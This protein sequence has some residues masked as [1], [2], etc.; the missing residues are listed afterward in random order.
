MLSILKTDS[1]QS[2]LSIRDLV[3]E[4]R[5]RESVVRAVDRV[6]FGVERGET[7]GIVGESGSGKSQTLMAALGLLASNANATGKVLFQGESLLDQSPGALNRI[8][9]DKIAMVFQDPMTALTPHLKI[10]RQLTE[11]LSAHQTVTRQQA[12]RRALDMLSAVRI[13]DPSRVFDSYPHAL[14]GGMRQRV[15][16]AIALICEPELLIADEPT[17]ALDV[18]VQAQILSLLDDI[19]RRMDLS[20]VLVSHDLGVIAQHC[21]RVVVMYAGRIVEVANAETLFNRPLHPYTRALLD[22]LPDIDG[23][24]Q[25]SL[26]TIPGQPPQPGEIGQGCSFAPRCPHTAD[27]CRLESPPLRGDKQAVACHFASPD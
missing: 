6:S 10:G 4:F 15:M 19:K 3:V 18:T 16:I 24:L 25:E 12:R 17:T 5:V 23:P 8:R 9:G 22:S 1:R 26:S 13:P 27:T 14:S 2:I 20:V 11:T 7:L 21:T